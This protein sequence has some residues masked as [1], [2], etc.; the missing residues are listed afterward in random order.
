[1]TS[2]PFFA[3]RIATSWPN[4]LPCAGDQYLLHPASPFSPSAISASVPADVRLV[5]QGLWYSSTRDRQAQRDWP[6]T[7]LD[8]QSHARCTASG[9]PCFPPCAQPNVNAVNEP[10]RRDQRSEQIAAAM[11]AV[12]AFGCDISVRCD[13][14]WKMV[15]CE[16]AWR[17]IASSEAGVMI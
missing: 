7:L 14:P 1:M 17:A 9:E 13:P 2:K 10:C 3:S 5:L 6:E 4:P 12:T 8:Q 11:T 15:M 16:C